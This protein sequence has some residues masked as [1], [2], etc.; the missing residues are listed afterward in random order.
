MK[1]AVITPYHKEPLWKLQRSHNS[2]LQQTDPCTHFLIA[3]GY[4][5]DELAS[6]DCRHII[7][8]VEHADNG[9]TPRGIGSLC[10][11]NEGFDVICYLDADNWYSPDHATSVLFTQQATAADVVF[12]YRHVVFPDGEIL[13]VEDPEDLSHTHA[14]TSCMVIFQPAFRALP[15]WC[16]MPQ[17]LGPRCDRVMFSLLASEFSCAWSEYKSVFFET[18]Y[19][20]HFR[21]AGKNIPEDVKFISTMDSEMLVRVNEQFAQRSY[22]PV[23]F[24][25]L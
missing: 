19:R 24:S 3:D 22:R 20:G 11:M 17:E 7:L 2:V 15:G 6:W 8:P 18:W 10:A 4:P 21:L 25:I 16:L 14:D 13:E 1:I 9:N 5:R 23:V 12:S